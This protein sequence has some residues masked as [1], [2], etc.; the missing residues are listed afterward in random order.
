MGEEVFF[1]AVCWLAGWLFL[2]RGGMRNLEKTGVSICWLWIARDAER[3]GLRSMDYGGESLVVGGG[4]NCRNF[5]L[6]RLPIANH[7]S[8]DCLLLEGRKGNWGWKS[9][10]L[11]AAKAGGKSLNAVPWTAERALSKVLSK[12]WKPRGRRFLPLKNALRT[13][14]FCWN[15]CETTSETCRAARTAKPARADS[16]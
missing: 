9:V 16:K 8:L 12:E 4:L 5:A 15:S 13:R 2:W 6:C 14:C 7:W 3:G 10:P 11:V 1:L